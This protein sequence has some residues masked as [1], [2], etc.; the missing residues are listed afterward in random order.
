ME[1]KKLLLLGL[2]I[3]TVLW[4]IASYQHVRAYNQM[5]EKDREKWGDAIVEY[6]DYYPVWLWGWGKLL[7]FLGLLIAF[8]WVTPLLVFIESLIKKLGR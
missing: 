2:C 7:L 4:L 8:A 6:R 5:I 1:G 3:V